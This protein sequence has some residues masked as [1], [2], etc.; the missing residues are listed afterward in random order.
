MHT[1]VYRAHINAQ[2]RLTLPAPARRA[3]NTRPGDEL[4]VRVEPDGVRLMTHAQALRR[5]QDVFATIAPQD[6]LLSE[7][8][9]RDRRAEAERE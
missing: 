3:L 8:V 1:E 5:A 9:L 4:V 7:E 2:G 6:V